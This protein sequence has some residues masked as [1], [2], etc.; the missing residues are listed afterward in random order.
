V[1]NYP[2]GRYDPAS[3]TSSTGPS[4]NEGRLSLATMTA[5]DRVCA[6]GGV[7][8]TSD[9]RTY[10]NTAEYLHPQVAAPM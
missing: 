8:D 5:D 9:E 4:L 10:Y 7:P 6:I 1:R 3:D 2:S